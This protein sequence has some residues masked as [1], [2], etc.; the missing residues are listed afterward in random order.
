MPR[1]A[2]KARRA[3]LRWVLF[4]A[5]ASRV[6]ALAHRNEFE[7]VFQRAL[8]SGFVTLH[9]SLCIRLVAAYRIHWICIAACS[10]S[11]AYALWHIVRLQYIYIYIVTIRCGVALSLR[12]FR[13]TIVFVV[14]RSQNVVRIFGSRGVSRVCSQIFD[15]HSI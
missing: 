14:A 3:S 15:V 5:F 9:V 13:E 8:L 12:S 11:S 10:V 7:M 2:T 1:A 6:Y 4:V